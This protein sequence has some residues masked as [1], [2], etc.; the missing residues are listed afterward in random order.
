MFGNTKDTIQKYLYYFGVWEPHISA[1]VSSSLK[2]GDYFIDIGAN[3]GYYTLMSSQLVGA[4]GKV[5]SIEA[6][7]KIFKVLEKHIAV[8]S[9]KNVRSICAAVSNSKGRLMVH[10]AT[11][12]NIG[13]TSVVRKFKN[14]FQPDTETEAAPLGDL[15]SEAEI[16]NAR[17]IKIDVEGA[18]WLVIDGMRPIFKALREDVEILLEVSLDSLEQFGKS[19]EDLLSELKQHG[20][21]AYVIRNEY[22]PDDYLYRVP[23]SRP[24]RLESHTGPLIDLV[25]S[26]A[27]KAYL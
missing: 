9:I 13:G 7:P 8:N 17:I 6:S 19:F 22:K 15:L 24:K 2:I 21:N 27:D 23:F 14:S 5:V 1:H 10:H 12:S 25:F 26:R 18:E 16:K 20:F 11:D 4:S 3:I